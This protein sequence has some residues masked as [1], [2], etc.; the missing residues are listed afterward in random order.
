MSSPIDE[1]AIRKSLLAIQNDETLSA[2]DKARRMHE[3]VNSSRRPSPCSLSVGSPKSI[4]SLSSHALEDEFIQELQRELTDEDREVSYAVGDVMG[5]QHYQR[6][7]KIRPECCGMWTVCR[8]CHNAEHE[9]HEIVRFAT[10]YM[11]CMH[12]TTV[13]KVG[14]DCH[15]CAKRMADYY[16]G[17][18]KMWSNDPQKPIFHCAECGI[19]RLGV[20]GGFKHCHTCGV[21]YTVETFEKHKCREGILEGNCPICGEHLGSSIDPVVFMRCSHSIHKS[22][23]SEHI[24]SSYVCPIC[25]KSLRDMNEYFTHIDRLLSTQRMPPEYRRLK[26]A[27]F[28][29]DCEAK[30]EASF[31]FMYHKC[32]KCGS[33]NTKVVKTFEDPNYVGPPEEDV[34]PEGAVETPDTL[35]QQ[36]SSEGEDEEGEELQQ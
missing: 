28:C 35:E 31:H 3:L 34:E 8:L 2:S 21:C 32:A 27:I 25:Q 16:C 13:Q 14:Q 23:F 15:K 33:Y 19:C 22:C 18:C 30:T 10:K 1:G 5:C 4:S 7:C 20:E 29:N 9:D 17:T 11:M 6:G 26:S 24:K 36:S 12:C